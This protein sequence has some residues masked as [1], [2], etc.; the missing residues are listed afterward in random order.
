M[1]MSIVRTRL[2]AFFGA[3]IALCLVGCSSNPKMVEGTT[4]NL[5]AYLPWE[6]NIYG[7]ELISY[8]NGIKVNS[9]SNQEFKV[10]REYASTNSWV[11]GLMESRE[12]SKTKVEVK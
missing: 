12:R 2:T 3:L 5:G 10:E 9:S 11:W 8:V 7:L 6:G 1:T 4:I